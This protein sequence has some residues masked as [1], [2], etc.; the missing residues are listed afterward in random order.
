MRINN[1]TSPNFGA[2]KLSENSRKFGYKIAKK[3]EKAGFDDIGTTDFLKKHDTIDKKAATANFLREVD[4]I[5]PNEFATIFFNG[6]KE[7][8]V[9]GNNIVLEHK[10][11]PYVQKH[12]PGAR[13][14]LGI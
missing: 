4:I 8:F 10:M 2:I 3:L 11:L 12:D 6:D 1:T 9:I 7:C 5:G 13:L 14:N